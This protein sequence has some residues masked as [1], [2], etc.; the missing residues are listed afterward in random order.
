MDDRVV[1]ILSCHSPNIADAAQCASAL[2]ASRVL[3]GSEGQRVQL[4]RGPMEISAPSGV[5][6]FQPG[7]PCPPA[8]LT[9][10]SDGGW[11]LR[12]KMWHAL[13]ARPPPSALVII[14][15]GLN[16]DM[17]GRPPLPVN[18]VFVNAPQHVIDAGRRTV[19]YSGGAVVAY[20]KGVE[21]PQLGEML[22]PLYNRMQVVPLG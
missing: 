14:T 3:S 20:D 7:Q 15:D 4:G 8:G 11:T 18:I 12:V 5:R 13:A 9:D 6:V 19:S 21:V 17:L 1:V 22:A 2:Q 10:E 16:L